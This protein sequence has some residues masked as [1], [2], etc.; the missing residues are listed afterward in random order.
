M[1]GSHCAKSIRNVGNFEGTPEPP[2]C[3]ALGIIAACR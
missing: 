1:L 2:F 3:V